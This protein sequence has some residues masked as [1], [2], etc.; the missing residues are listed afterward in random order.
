MKMKKNSAGFTL[1]EVLLALAIL[2]IALTAI[3]RSTSQNTRNM[4]YLQNKTIA[5]WVAND[6]VNQARVGLVKLPF[7]SEMEEET[8]V[9]GRNWTW[10]GSLTATPNPRIKKIEVD[11]YQSSDN[12]KMAHLVSFVYAPQ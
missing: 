4:V 9:L 6:V 7:E 1:I 5:Y 3:I 2:A 12:A 11:V 8:E 10:K